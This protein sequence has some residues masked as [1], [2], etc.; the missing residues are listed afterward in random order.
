[1][2]TKRNPLSSPSH[3]SLPIHL[4]RSHMIRHQ[5][6]EITRARIDREPIIGRLA[7][8]Q[9]RAVLPEHIRPHPTTRQPKTRRLPRALDRAVAARRRAVAVL[10]QQARLPRRRARC[11]VVRDPGAAPALRGADGPGRRV[12]MHGAEVE[13]ADG[14]VGREVHALRESV[15]VAAVRAGAQAEALVA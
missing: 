1:M 13:G 9:R 2:Y 14:E 15:G 10:L 4:D 7:R 12:E 8:T 6:R 11:R 5:A 3:H